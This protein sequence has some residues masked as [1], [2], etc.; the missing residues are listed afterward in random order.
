MERCPS[1][2]AV[3]HSGGATNLSGDRDDP[4]VRVVATDVRGKCTTTFQGTSSAA[5]LA[6]GAMALV[7]EAN[8]NLTY[9][10]VMYLIAKTAKIPNIE[11]TD[12][13]II[14]GANYHVNEKYGFGALDVS[15]MVQEAQKW[16]NV[17][18]RYSCV[19]EFNGKY[20]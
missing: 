13:W 17:D 8:P 2:M 7:L 10:D 4:K 18:E 1:T 14:N 11:E 6:A 15:Q 3:V 16:K 9:R 5:P 12:G 20:P 19:V